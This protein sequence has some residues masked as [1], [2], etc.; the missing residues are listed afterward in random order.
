MKIVLNPIYE[1]LRT[2]V[3][4]LPEEFDRHGE[5]IYEERNLSLRDMTFAKARDMFEI[6][7]TVTETVT[8]MLLNT[9]LE[10]GTLFCLTDSNISRKLSRVGLM[11]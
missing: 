4:S 7:K 9:Y 1:H 10:N 2:W 5:V 8:A 11:A 6:R 3:M